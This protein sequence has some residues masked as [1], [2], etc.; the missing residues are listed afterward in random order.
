MRL[1]IIVS[2]TAMVPVVFQSAP[3]EVDMCWQ[4]IGKNAMVRMCSIEQLLD[5]YICTSLI[6]DDCVCLCRR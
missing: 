1:T 4:K 3:V 6:F 5:L 2:R